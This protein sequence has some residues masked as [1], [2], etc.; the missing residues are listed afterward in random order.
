MGR[1]SDETSSMLGGV[2]WCGDARWVEFRLMRA[3]RP[4]PAGWF[5]LRC[6]F[7]SSNERG[8]T[9][10]SEESDLR[11]RVD[12]LPRWG[13]WERRERGRWESARLR[14]I[15]CGKEHEGAQAV[16]VDPCE[17]RYSNT[18]SSVLW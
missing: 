3:V 17:S 1:A 8:C 12:Q 7:L 18:H 5:F 2:G 9:G 10:V 15:S 13:S 16:I 4:Q 14:L 11:K 6:A